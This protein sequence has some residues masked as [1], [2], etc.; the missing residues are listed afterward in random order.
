[1]LPVLCQDAHLFWHGKLKV[2]MNSSL[3]FFDLQGGFMDPF[4]LKGI[5]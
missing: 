2:L 1:M 3:L 5:D 4:I